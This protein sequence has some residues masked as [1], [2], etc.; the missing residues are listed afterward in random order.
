L[1]NASIRELEH[2][3]PLTAEMRAADIGH[4]LPGAKQISDW[5]AKHKIDIYLITGR[6]ANIESQTVQNLSGFV[7]KKIYFR[8]L[9]MS[10]LVHKILARQDIGNIT[11][12]AGDQP[13]DYI[14]GNTGFIVKYPRLYI[15]S[16]A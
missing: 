7:Y 2:A 8:P 5:C 14:G 10:T 6:T 11:L 12:T 9:G 4:F 15:G 3:L 13:S 1:Q 16:A